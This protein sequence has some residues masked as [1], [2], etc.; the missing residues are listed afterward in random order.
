[1]GEREHHTHGTFS[2]ADLG[3]T[4]QKAAASFIDD[5]RK[6]WREKTDCRAGFITTECQNGPKP[7]P[8]ATPAT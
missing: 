5:L 7:T 2:W 3:T 1:M 6:Q 8:T 4:D